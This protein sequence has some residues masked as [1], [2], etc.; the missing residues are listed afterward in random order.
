MRAKP[1]FWRA[2]YPKPAVTAGVAAHRFGPLEVEPN[3]IA[4]IGRGMK[5]SVDVEGASRGYALEV[6]GRHFEL[7]ELGPIGSNGLA[8][9]ADFLHP[10]S[11]YEDRSCP[12]GFRIFNK[13]AGQMF[14]A[15]IPHSPYDVVGWTGNY[16]P[17]KCERAPQ[18]RAQPRPLASERCGCPQTTCASSCASTR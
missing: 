4:V 12:D 8:N 16:L 13:F 3:E 17:Y 6:Y 1:P 14:E 9:A 5:F 15:T 7:P 10:S 18:P 11:A 2:P